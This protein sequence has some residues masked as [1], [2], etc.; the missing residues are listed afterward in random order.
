MTNSLSLI[1]NGVVV[2]WEGQ[3]QVWSLWSENV[4]LPVWSLVCIEPV[5]S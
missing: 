3:V 1:V 2:S 4:A 5:E